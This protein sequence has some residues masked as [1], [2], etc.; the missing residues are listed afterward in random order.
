MSLVFADAVCSKGDPHDLDG[1][2]HVMK[3]NAVGTFNV[4]RL[5]AMR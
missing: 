5:A 4:L 1:F 2:S 3:V